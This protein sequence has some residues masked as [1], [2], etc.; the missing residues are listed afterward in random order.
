MQ[1]LKRVIVTIFSI[2][3]GLVGSH[4]VKASGVGLGYQLGLWG[5]IA[6]LFILMWPIAKRWLVNHH[7]LPRVKYWFWLHVICGTIGP[8]LILAHSRLIL[9]SLNATVAFWL[10]LFLVF[11]GILGLWFTK[12][13]WGVGLW[14]EDK[15]L[16]I[17]KPVLPR[18]ARYL[19][20]L[21]YPVAWVFILVAVAH[22]IAVHM[23]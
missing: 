19:L 13:N 15:N 6:M 16:G 14:L 23:Y 21:H 11:T 7:K 22:V 17:L 9:L 12:D 10:M 18:V 2:L 8:S 20:S 1:K 4:W 3:L 5:G